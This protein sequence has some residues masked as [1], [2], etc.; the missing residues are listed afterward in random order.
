MNA[1]RPGPLHGGRAFV[2]GE[3]R[4]AERTARVASM[5]FFSVAVVSS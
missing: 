4:Y 3:A 1:R 2:V 5:R